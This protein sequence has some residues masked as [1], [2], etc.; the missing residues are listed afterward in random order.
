MRRTAAIGLLLIVTLP[1]GA[2][3]DRSSRSTRGVMPRGNAPQ[4]INAET[5]IRAAA[6]TLANEKKNFDRDLEVLRHLRA[7]DAAL[8]D[9]MQ[10]LI[11]VEKA[12]EEVSAAK[13]LRPEFV[14]LQGIVRAQEELEN[15]RRSPSTADFGRLRAFV[16]SEATTPAMRVAARNGLRLQDETLA[17][18]RVEELIAT[19]LRTL[20]EITGESL[21]AADQ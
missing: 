9:P 12:Y 5:A 17:W 15:A 2:Q 7:V 19:H 18:L 13:Q 6:E 11:A 14:T 10:P 21:R 3:S 8:T 4:A 1:L 16:R 20:A